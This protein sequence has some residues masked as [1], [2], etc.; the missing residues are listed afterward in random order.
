MTSARA[1]WILNRAGSPRLR[2]LRT[3]SHTAM[4]MN[5][6]SSRSWL[7]RL[8]EKTYSGA[9]SSRSVASPAIR[10]LPGE[11]AIEH[12]GRHDEDRRDERVQVLLERDDIEA[13][14]GEDRRR[15]SLV[16]EPVGVQVRRASLEVA[17]RG[18]RPDGLCHG[19]RIALGPSSVEAGDEIRAGDQPEPEQRQQFRQ[20]RQHG[21]SV[22]PPTRKGVDAVGLH[23][24][25]AVGPRRPH[26]TPVAVPLL[27]RLRVS[28]AIRS[29][30]PPDDHGGQDDAEDE[31]RSHGDEDV[32]RDLGHADCRR[33]GRGGPGRDPRATSNMLRNRPDA[34]RQTDHHGCAITSRPGHAGRARGD[35]SSVVSRLARQRIDGRDAGPAPRGPPRTCLPLAAASSVR[36]RPAVRCA[37][38]SGGS[39]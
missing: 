16:A 22:R 1:R 37:T 15:H 2:T 39:G 20:R 31:Q 35:A 17:R 11:L 3:N 24:R 10:P 21:R 38:P 13:R 5:V 12:P 8:I 25:R 32:D 18:E 28:G 7:A 34:G 26:A 36:R 4:N 33:E 19:A 14:E 30:A 29:H 9:T 6:R 23:A 27:G